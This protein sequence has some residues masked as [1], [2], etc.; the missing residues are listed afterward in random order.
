MPAIK[1]TSKLDGLELAYNLFDYAIADEERKQSIVL[2]TVNDLFPDLEEGEQKVELTG[3][4][5][6]WFYERSIIKADKI[7]GASL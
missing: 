3:Y 6:Q 7:R 2:N 4:I 5:A 1:T